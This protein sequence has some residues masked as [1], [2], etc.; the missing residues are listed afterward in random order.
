MFRFFLEKPVIVLVVIL[1]ISL[2][3]VLSYFRVPVQMIPDLDPRVISVQTR[4]PGA[5][6]QDV[7]KEIIIEQE[8]YLQ[9][10]PGLERMVSTASTGNASIELEFPYGVEINQALIQVNNALS[11]VPDYP[12]NVDEPRITSSSF[13]SNAFMSFS[14]T[15][16][17]G[18]P[19]GIK[20]WADLVQPGLEIVH[21]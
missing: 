20:T 18:N 6:P 13:S 2:F 7:E 9:R 8:Q 10:I 12:E 14:I 1:I 17:P 3:G 11:Q 21:L 15:P 16:I 5:T 4:W 19:L